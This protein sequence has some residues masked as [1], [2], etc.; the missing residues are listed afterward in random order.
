[1]KMKKLI[2]YY[3]ANIGP[4][5]ARKQV[6]VV[7]GPKSVVKC[8]PGVFWWLNGPRDQLFIA[9]MMNSLKSLEIGIN[10]LLIMMSLELMA[11]IWSTFTI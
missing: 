7:K 9:S 10:V 11:S 6:I 1:M 2:H 3:N 5:R 4:W 8:P